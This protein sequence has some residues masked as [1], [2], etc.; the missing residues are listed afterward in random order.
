[1]TT[2]KILTGQSARDKL[3]K[4]INELSEAVIGTLGPK[5][6]NVSIQQ[7]Y[8]PPRITKDGVTVAKSITLKDP[9]ENMGVQMLKEASIKTF[10]L[11][12]DGTTTAI[13]LAQEIVKAG[14]HV[15]STEKGVNIIEVKRGIDTITHYLVEEL[16]GMAKIVSSHEE[17]KQI[18]TNSAN[19]DKEIGQIV[20]DAF[21]QAGEAR[22]IMMEESKTR[23][24]EMVLMEGMEWAS[25]YITP[26]FINRKDQPVCELKNPLILVTSRPIPNFEVTIK[27]LIAQLFTVNP[28]ALDFFK[29]RDFLIVC[30]EIDQNAIAGL[31]AQVGSINICV[32][33]S[34]G[35]AEKRDL[36]EDLA[37]NCGAEFHSVDKAI[38]FNELTHKKN[39]VFF[40]SAE[41]VIVH[42]NKTVFVKGACDVEELSHRITTLKEQ[43]VSEQDFDKQDT[44]QKRIAA[45][46]NKMAVIRVG[47]RSELE[48]K[49]KLDRVDDALGAVKAA[50]EEGIVPGGGSS[51]VY[52]Y[53]AALNNLSKEIQDSIPTSVFNIFASVVRRPFMQLL[54]NSGKCEDEAT[55]FV[56][57]LLAHCDSKK[58]YFGID[59]RS[60]DF[61]FID[62]FEKGII[63]PL[64]V[65]RLALEHAAS[66]AGLIFTT[67]A[68]IAEDDSVEDSQGFPSGGFKIRMP[69]PMQDPQ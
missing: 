32:V 13:V 30:D 40:G 34:P 54:L 60:N 69:S 55:E 26:D 65:V 61:T 6:R 31:V 10:E 14:M 8:G 53:V 64:K 20:A 17:I 51:F 66:V 67:Q 28:D 16:K 15:T 48:V 1:M 9:F 62:M 18:A 35:Y 42:R 24:T 46:S 41:K 37:I 68:M 23:T 21:E 7:S 52:A 56:S 47:G 39:H 29:G 49:E 5:G 22:V 25:G 38:M 59:I 43:M 19:G 11:A 58:G 27:K 3:I 33:K 2:K 57:Q 44:L 36:M 4:G 45:L 63:D 50:S 12:G